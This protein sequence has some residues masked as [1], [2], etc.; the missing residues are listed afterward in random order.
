M[1]FLKEN[2]NS[3]YK[4]LERAKIS[5]SKLKNSM[6]LN[7]LFKS[8]EN[9]YSTSIPRVKISINKYEKI[10]Q[11]FTN[12]NIQKKFKKQNSMDD[13]I[14][15]QLKEYINYSNFLKKQLK[16]NND[17]NQ[18]RIN[19]YEKLNKKF[20]E[21]NIQN[22]VINQQ[23]FDFQ[24]ENK[25]LKV[26]NEN[27]KSKLKDINSNIN[28]NYE[29][30]LK[31]IL[32][33]YE[34]LK[35]KKKFYKK[36]NKNLEKSKKEYEI[37][38]DKLQKSLNLINLS[39]KNNNLLKTSNECYQQNIQKFKD[40]KDKY[41]KSR[42]SFTQNDRSNI[43]NII[44]KQNISENDFDIN[45]KLNNTNFNK[46]NK[47][48]YNNNLNDN[49]IIKNIPKNN[50]SKLL[51]EKNN[52]KEKKLNN[53]KFDGIEDLK[54]NNINNEKNLIK[55]PKFKISSKNQFSKSSNHSPQNKDKSNSE[56]KD[57]NFLTKKTS[58]SFLK[59][60]K[61]ISNLKDKNITLNLRNNK[62]LINKNNS[63]SSSPLNLKKKKNLS[64]EKEDYNL[65]LNE[66]ISLIKE[67]GNEIEIIKEQFKILNF[68]LLKNYEKI[69]YKEKY[70]REKIKN[71]K[72]NLSLEQLNGLTQE[73]LD[74]RVEMQNKYENEIKRLKK[75]INENPNL[76][77]EKDN[78]YFFRNEKK[79]YIFINNKLDNL[80]AIEKKY[81]FMEI[82]NDEELKQEKT[83]QLTLKS[84]KWEDPFNV[85][86]NVIYLTSDLKT[87]KNF[88][89]RK[90]NN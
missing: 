7:D 44:M 86:K 75:K 45:E 36:M 41:I 12:K 19:N 11:N 53:N 88:Y 73:L 57:L 54:K 85:D 42:N 61:D 6:S 51:N 52:E 69:N 80:K 24:E 70:K 89:M 39:S 26:E 32:E 8:K 59:I 55:S 68:Q 3:F 18:E 35:E 74:T 90:N 33:K 65:R 1:I 72:V 40:N 10:K 87:N 64:E 25:R 71:N 43:D 60:L 2:I 48:L 23:L 16:K 78:N 79:E 31:S 21:I 37:L 46:K 81:N 17:I 5:L 76:S 58:P 4:P 22:K 14:N 50:C 67:K 83:S 84:N 30:N 66:L 38:I 13:L 15:N 82:Y 29:Y 63:K 34:M 62:N 27:L 9:P 77:P 56:K 28:L 47:D 49:I 20:N